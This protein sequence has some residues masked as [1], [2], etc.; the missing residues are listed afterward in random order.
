MKSPGQPSFAKVSVLVLM[1]VSYTDAFIVAAPRAPRVVSGTAT[2]QQDGNLTVINAG[3]RSIINYQGFDIAPN[4]TV[5]F[6]QPNASSTV[7][8]RV[9]SPNPTNIFGQLQANGIVYIVNPYGVYFQN[10]SVLNVGGLI[11]AA[12]HISDQ[13]FAA[14]RIHF[15]DLAGDVR[16]D[17][18]L[19]AD[20]R[21]A[22]MGANVTNTGKMSVARGVAMMTSG[23]DIYVG[24]KGGNIY[25]QSNGSATASA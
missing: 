25:V 16:N 9:I 23:S 20:N 21:I 3:N 22:L 24:E 8:N 5:R 12:G 19:A 1:L 17:G 14:G 6:V 15:T 13:D 7:L 4:E 10:G 11:A 18:V 2:I